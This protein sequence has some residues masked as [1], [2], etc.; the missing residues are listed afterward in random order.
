MVFSA[1]RNGWSMGVHHLGVAN[2]YRL[3]AA[4]ALRA[5]R[6]DLATIREQHID[7][8]SID[9]R[10]GEI[11]HTAGEHADTMLLPALRRLDGINQ[12]IG[13]A[14]GDFRC[15][16]L[17]SRQR[18]WHKAKELH[19][20]H[21]SIEAGGL[22]KSQ[23]TPDEAQEPRTHEKRVQREPTPKITL[24]GFGDSSLLDLGTGGFEEFGI[25]DARRTSRLAGQAAEA[26]VHLIRER[27]RDLQLPIGYRSKQGNTTAWAVPLHL[28]LD[29]S[30]AGG[31]AHAAMHALLQD[32]VIEI[33]EKRNGAHES[34]E[35]PIPRE[36][37]VLSF[38]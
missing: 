31:Q 24:G 35:S 16:R 23:N 17:Q 27:L 4:A 12:L 14:R 7:G 18:G 32:G 22:I 20:A 15:L 9:V 10:E 21:E 3:R 37:A 26:V 2:T 33:F 19:A 29:V 6:D 11:L 30:G 13:E 36:E 28:R 25:I 38:D 1:L 5:R 34:V 8:V